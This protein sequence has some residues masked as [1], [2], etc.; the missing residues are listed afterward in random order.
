MK[1]LTRKM[2]WLALFVRCVS[3][4]MPTTPVGAA[5]APEVVGAEDNTVPLEAWPLKDGREMMYVCVK[6]RTTDPILMPRDSF[7]RQFGDGSIQG[8]V[9]WLKR[10]PRIRG[11]SN[12]D[13]IFSIVL[14]NAVLDAKTGDNDIV[15]C[16]KQGYELMELKVFRGKGGVRQDISRISDYD[17]TYSVQMKRTAEWGTIY[18]NGKVLGKR[19]KMPSRFEPQKALPVP[20]RLRDGREIVDVNLSGKVTDI[21]TGKPVHYAGIW[22]KRNPT[23]FA[24]TD[25]KGIWNMRMEA[26]GLRPLTRHR[27]DSICIS[28]GGY[29]S[30]E[31]MMTRLY[32]G[33]VNIA[34][35]KHKL[36]DTGK[37]I[38]MVTIPQS[39]F[40]M[41]DGFT[42]GGGPGR[43]TIG[44]VGFYESY[45]ML[46]VGLP[47]YSIGKTLVTW[48]QY[49]KVLTWAR[50]HGYDLEDVRHF[51]HYSVGATPTEDPEHPAIGLDFFECVK[52]CNAASEMEGS[53]PAYYTPDGT[54]YRKGKYD[55]PQVKW[56]VN[57]YRLPTGA[58]WEYAATAG[59]HFEY[60]WPEGFET[61]ADYAYPRADLFPELYP[62]PNKL[63]GESTHPL[64]RKKPNEF[65]LFDVVGMSV[66]RC[67]GWRGH[68]KDNDI[69][70]PKGCT[71]SEAISYFKGMY[72]GYAAPRKDTAGSWGAW[73]VGP[74]FIDVGWSYLRFRM[75]MPV[76]C[77]YG[78]AL[79]PVVSSERGDEDVKLPVLPDRQRGLPQPVKPETITDRIELVI[80]PT[81]SFHMGSANYFELN[82]RQKFRAYTEVPEHKVQLSAFQIAKYETTLA[83]WGR[84][85]GWA[86][87][88]GYE[89]DNAGSKGQSSSNDERHPVTE[90][91]WFDMLKWCNAASEMQGLEP[92]YYL[93]S[94]KDMPYRK[95]QVD[96]PVVDWAAGGYRLPTEAEWEY[97]A[98]GGIDD[99]SY[100]W[101]DHTDKA[102]GWYGGWM[103]D[104][105]TDY[106]ILQEFLKSLPT[107]PLPSP[108]VQPKPNWASHP[109]GQKIGNR[110]GLYD[111]LGNVWERCWDRLAPYSMTCRDVVNPKGPA[112][113]EAVDAYL[114]KYTDDIMSVL[115]KS[116][117]AD[118]A[119]GIPKHGGLRVLKGRSYRSNIGNP[120]HYC[121]GLSLRSGA[122][123]DDVDAQCG[124]RVAGSAKKV[125]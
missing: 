36:K 13:G 27:T 87:R 56:K 101:G 19:S 9:F 103:G 4:L 42:Q 69:W 76:G 25:K 94:K 22:L 114:I 67:S 61:I 81:G 10:N 72:N 17:L 79:R 97:A 52:W 41:G 90:I 64:G 39:F 23:M 74:V 86:I 47:E 95:S 125:K 100:Y 30:K 29:A 44:D 11:V 104:S 78:G 12:H 21:K 119:G 83:Q 20:L 112:S 111:V 91:S 75:G 63:K 49:E 16:Y 82:Q 120:I 115:P 71:R 26:V 8:A 34:I 32:D 122:L 18:K 99:A 124:F 24:M 45:P 59:T 85:Y 28:A 14:E 60:H 92:C 88:N 1:C 57:G 108:K 48:G 3:M 31:V 15:C 80:V 40:R 89:F 68:Y 113:K 37:L 116:I 118:A 33:K 123:P 50:E 110:Y 66:A 105:N 58:E 77:R 35:S 5:E 109:V 7:C 96:N 55:E 106:P 51:V 107:G 84:V 98:M 102:Y 62:E 2:M 93:D 73:G 46:T 43:S 121:N 38:P 117:Y 6:G 54:V 70:H 65:G 53:T